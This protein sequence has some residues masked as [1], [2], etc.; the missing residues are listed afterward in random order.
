MKKILFGLL[1]T[2]SFVSCSDQEK[3]RYFGEEIIKELP[4]NTRFI[5]AEWNRDELWVNVEDTIKKEFMFI[6]Y[7]D[8]KRSEGRVVFKQK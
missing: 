8:K 6:Q 4:E 2:L 3:A 7:A 1:I 5:S